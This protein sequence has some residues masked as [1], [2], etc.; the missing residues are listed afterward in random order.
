MGLLRRFSGAPPCV[1]F[2]IFLFLLT[3]H[4]GHA[5][6]VVC[7][8]SDGCS[9]GGIHTPLIG[10][11]TPSGHPVTVSTTKQGWHNL[12][13]VARDPAAQTSYARYGATR[14]VCSVCGGVEPCEEPVALTFVGWCCVGTLAVS[15]RG[16]LP[17]ASCR[18]A[19]HVWCRS[20]P[21]A[22]HG[23]TTSRLRP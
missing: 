13:L 21:T 14:C 10:I 23:T 4:G 18:V 3:P 7:W 22:W 19:F 5:V 15:C 11:D 6:C 8:L 9:G 20:D 2:C 16:A 1:E 12:T 17:S